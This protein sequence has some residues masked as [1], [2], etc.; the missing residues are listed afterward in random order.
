MS[1][2]DPVKEDGTDQKPVDAGGL[3]VVLIAVV[4]LGVLIL[5]ALF[6]VDL[7]GENSDSPWGKQTGTCFTM[8]EKL[9]E[10]IGRYNQS[11]GQ[12]CL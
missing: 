5:A 6:L 10:E 1:Q 7:G 12:C 2:P 3:V 11:S 8:T 9:C 4:G